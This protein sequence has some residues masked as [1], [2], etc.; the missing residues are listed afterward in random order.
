VRLATNG[1]PT[2]TSWDT[3]A[4]FDNGVSFQSLLFGPVGVGTL[5]RSGTGAGAALGLPSTLLPLTPD[6]A[7]PVLGPTVSSVLD[8]DGA[9][10][11]ALAKVGSTYYLWYA[12]TAEDGGGPALFLATSADGTTWSRAN[13]GSPVLQGTPGAFDE[14]GVSGADVVYNP[15]DPSA[16]FKAWYSG[17][18]DV[19]GGIGYA[20][21]LDGITWTKHTGG[22]AL[23]L[24]V[25]SHGVAGSADSFS[26]ADPS[27][28]LEGSTWKMWYT[29]DDSS[30]KRIAY[31]TSPDGVTWAKGGKVIAPEDPGTSANIAFGAFAPTVWKT[32]SGYAMVLSGRKIVGGATFQTKLMS[33]TSS[34]GITWGAPTVALNPSGSSSNFDF[35]NLNSPELLQDAGAPT[36]YKL[37]Y[38]GNTIDENGNFHTR[39][40]LA[41]SANGNSFGKVA[42]A[43]TGGAVLD[44]GMGGTALDAR[45]ASGL[46]VAA[47]GGSGAKLVGFYWG[48]RGSDFKPRLGEATS[49]D[50][51]SWTKVAASGD[52]SSV[53]SLPTGSNPAFQFEKGGHRDPSV[54]YDAGTYD[55]Y[56]TALDAGGSRSIGF[57]S[58][59]E[60]PVTKQPNN[61]SWSDPAVQLLAG[62]GSGFDASEVSHPTVLKDGVTYLMYY[63]GTDSGG[64]SRIGRATSAT[65]GSGFTAG[66]SAV[67]DVGGSGSFDSTA[68]DDPVVVKA[69]AGDYRMLY[70]GVDADGIKRVGYATSADGLTWVKRGVVLSPSGSAFEDDEAG[71]EATG[72]LVDGATL[73]VWAN[74]IDRTGRTR[75]EHATIAFPTPG[76]PQPGVPSGWATY[77][78]GDASTAV[79]DFRQIA[80]VSSGSTVDLSMSFLQPYSSGGNEFWSDYFPVTASSPSEVLNMLLTVHGVRWRARLSTPASTPTVDSVQLTHAPVSFASSGSAATGPIAAAAG[81]TVAAWGS[82]TVNTSLFSPSG[83]GS[84][85]ATVRVL[86]AT[87]GQQ[88]A[89]SA[90]STGG[91]TTVPLA[92][93]PAASHQALRLAFDLQSDGQTTPRV[94]SFK[95]LYSTQAAPLVLTLAASMPS[96]VY[97]RTVTLTGG[98]LQGGTALVGAPVSLWAQPLGAASFGQVAALTT[99]TGGTF[100]AVQKPTKKTLYKV[101]YSGVATEPSVTV[102]VAHLLTL[103]VVRKGSKGTIRGRLGPTHPGR[104]VVVQMSTGSTWKT[105]AKLKSGRLST[106]S[107]VRKLKPKAKYKFRAQTAADNDHLAG[108]SAVFYLNRMKVALAVKLA[109]RKATFSGVVKPAHAGRYL[110]VQKLVGARWVALGKAKLS[111]RSTYRL[112][113]A[114]APGTYDLRAVTLSDK[115][116]WGGESRTWHLVVP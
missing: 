114:L 59:P 91:D 47:P 18:A 26:A 51:S 3:D 108:L 64:T 29:G 28:L 52:G 13:S 69:G 113:K 74:G 81:R 27:V 48:T 97:G 46:S 101:S 10:D 34:D 78:L 49:S 36:P 14:D 72:M 35:S 50:G 77:Q 1:V 106:F 96:V 19:F 76:G 83:G 31:A 22:G 105:I 85:G 25:V 63:A 79:R 100:T 6:G 43:Q 87:T 2:T 99:A 39:I 93:I 56:F 92:S 94:N 8:G 75:G 41:T 66:P 112:T 11:A 58:T 21:S 62:D 45:Q 88:L 103:S 70:T 67:L 12:G 5:L 23:P 65:A 40:G 4:D 115:D 104:L 102:S 90:L 110:I 42:G 20:T 95:V 44:A 30:K 109:G 98:L 89:S 71:L 68:V 24:P 73:H 53:L 7:N 82:L 38:S 37:Y 86:D 61:A 116:H 16:P 60:V 57:A 9:D 54:L 17:R 15:V 84:G 33:S 111:A 80:R 55:L 32:G 107:A